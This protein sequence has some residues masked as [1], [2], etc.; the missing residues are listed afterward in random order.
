M[1]LVGVVY[2]WELDRISGDGGDELIPTKRE[3]NDLVIGRR[4][5]KEEV[6]VGTPNEPRFSVAAGAAIFTTSILQQSAPTSNYPNFQHRNTAGGI[7][8]PQPYLLLC[9]L[10]CTFQFPPLNMFI[11]LFSLYV[12][13]LFLFFFLFFFLSYIY[14]FLLFTFTFHKSYFQIFQTTLNLSLF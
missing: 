9:Y 14:L 10:H 8:H 12:S 3:G 4:D 5:L 13:C 1:S 7:R 2:G 11:P 6:G